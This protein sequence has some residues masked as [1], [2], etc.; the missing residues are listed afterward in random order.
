MQTATGKV[1]AYKD[2]NIPP[3]P[4]VSAGPDWA[5]VLTTISPGDA[6]TLCAAVATLYPHDA[7]DRL[8]Y[9]RV[10]AQFDRVARQ[11]PEA[12]EMLGAFC[13]GL[14]QS[15]V[16]PFAALAESYRVQALKNLEAAPAFFFVQRLAVRYLYDDVEV[17]AAFGYEGAS[18]QLGGYLKRG[19]DDLDWLP[20]L[21]NE[22]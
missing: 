11:S 4:P 18:V 21:P 15:A 5:Q 1:T 16:L 22:I 14:N 7:L 6:E 10:I 20:P 3:A 8:I 2:P 9:R 17:W 19:F 13:E 12:V